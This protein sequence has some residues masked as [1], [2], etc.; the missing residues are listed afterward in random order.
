MREY[1]ELRI[2]IWATDSKKYLVFANGPAAAA[3]IITLEKSPLDYRQAVDLLLEEE[4]R[5]RPPDHHPIRER[6]R[7]LGQE[8][9]ALF[10]PEPIRSCLNESLRLAVHKQRALRIRLDVAPELQDIPFEICC[11]PLTDPLGFLALHP[12]ISLV[13]SIAGAPA[14]PLRIPAPTEARGP[15]DLLVVVASPMDREPL[16]VEDELQQLLTTV[17]AFAGMGWIKLHFLGGSYDISRQRA[18]RNNLRNRLAILSSRPCAVLIIAHGEYDETKQEGVI[19]LEREDGSPDVVSSAVLAGSLAVAY[20]LRLVVLNLCMGTRSAP[21]EPFSGMAQAVIAA[22]IP[23]VA[24]MRFEVSYEAASSFSPAL[25]AA[26]CRNEWVD[27]ALI[28]GRLAMARTEEETTLEWS[29]PVLFLHT[30]YSHGWLFKLPELTVSDQPVIDLLHED[31]QVLHHIRAGNP[32]SL[33]TLERVAWYLRTQGDWQGVADTAAVALG[34][35]PAHPTFNNLRQEAQAELRLEDCR[36]LCA[37]L[38]CEGLPHGAIPILKRLQ[39][40]LQHPV[41]PCLHTEVQTRLGRI[42]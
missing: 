13:R 37:M 39:G 21:F 35:A 23:A 17:G 12:N 10:L 41:L 40:R 27:E 28:A 18:T 6:V 25:F 8:L 16:D 14:S 5:R 7:Q 33:D 4:F 38:A 11:T 24:T 3:A 30:A 22:G 31:Y 36:Q 32:V 2:R 9:F 29:T 34:V 1:E 20:G 26:L 42:S 19:L 15:L